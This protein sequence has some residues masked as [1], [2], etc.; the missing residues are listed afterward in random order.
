MVLV[1]RA[2][3]GGA[4]G[5]RGEREIDAARGGRD[6]GEG[7]VVEPGEDLLAAVFHRLAAA[8]A[9]GDLRAAGAA[10]AEAEDGD[11]RLAATAGEL[12]RL[13]GEV[14]AVGDE[15][16]GVVVALERGELLQREG[17][18]GADV[19]LAAR[20]GVRAGG[21]ERRAEESGV[22]REGADHAGAVAEGDEPGAVA[23]EVG[24]EVGQI[25]LRAVEAVGVDVLREHGA[26]D[27]EQ[28]Q[29]VAGGGDGGL[30][31]LAP[32]RAGEGGDAEGEPG[33]AERELG[34]EDAAGARGADGGGAE[35]GEPG[36]AA[37]ARPDGEGGPRGQEPEEE[38]NGGMHEVHAPSIP[39]ARG[40]FK[41]L[42]KGGRVW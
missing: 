25:G 13:A 33:G 11:A 34:G 8:V 30:L 28:D 6:G 4:D 41:R 12:E 36:A 21:V 23:A 20:G 26:G 22:G 24:D 42:R 15:D 40:E 39:Q 16:D 14:L 3:G 31:A 37:A 38:Q 27:V 17:E 9:D 10:H 29:D 1:D 7:A 5:D 32:L 35:E 18:R 2:E 19:R